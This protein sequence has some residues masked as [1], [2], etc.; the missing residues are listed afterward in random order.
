M[1]AVACTYIG[2]CVGFCL[3]FVTAALMGGT[4]ATDMDNTAEERP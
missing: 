2:L 4:K 1:T 3:G